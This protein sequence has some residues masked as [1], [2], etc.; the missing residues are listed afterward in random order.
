MA[1]PIQK[2]GITDINQLLN[3]TP[4]KTDSSEIGTTDMVGGIGS[5]V[6]G[7]TQLAV[8]LNQ[9]GKARRLPFPS[10]MEAAGPLQANRQLYQQMYQTGLGSERENMMRT[11]MALQRAQAMNAISERSPQASAY[12]TRVAGL[13]NIQGEEAIA[14]ADI[15]A[16]QQALYG[17]ENANAALTSLG[18]KQIESEREYKL[19]A[20]RAA[21]AAIKSG[22]ENIARGAM[23]FGGAQ[24]IV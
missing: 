19:M 17:I 18:L 4:P 1:G 7:L 5:G 15:R 11:N 2:G 8:G 20:Q 24:Q 3:F 12:M 21:G 10:F 14:Q 23:I 9:L 22:T 6:M 13:S 16:R